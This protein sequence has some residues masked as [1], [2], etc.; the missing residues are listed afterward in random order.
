MIN[1][2]VCRKQGSAKSKVSWA[3]QRNSLSLSSLPFLK[4]QTTLPVNI[5]GRTSEQA[6]LDI[7]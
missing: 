6:S 5:P 3:V 4:G 7:H 1:L 2:L